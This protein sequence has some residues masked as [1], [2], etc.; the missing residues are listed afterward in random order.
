MGIN[1]FSGAPKDLLERFSDEKELA[2]HVHLIAVSTLNETRKNQDLSELMNANGISVCD[3]K[4]VSTILSWAGS[5]I[6]R[7]RGSDFLR[8]FFEFDHLQNRHFFLGSTKETLEKLTSEIRANYPETVIAGCHAPPFS[9]ILDLRPIEELIVQSEANIVWIGLGSPKQDYIACHLTTQLKIRTVAVGA[10]FDFVSKEK[11]EAPN[12]LQEYGLEWLFRLI[13]EPR[14]LWK[15]Y[16]LG[17]FNFLFN[18]PYSIYLMKR[19]QKVKDN[20]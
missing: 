10:A 19:E 3:S 16:L 8:K 18:L 9:K 13:L 5:P 4:P 17:N 2:L 15:R 1:I 6:H 14:R 7:Q 11:K 12:F 20:E